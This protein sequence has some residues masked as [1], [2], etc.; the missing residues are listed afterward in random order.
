MWHLWACPANS[1][2]QL[3]LIE[4]PLKETLYIIW[5]PNHNKVKMGLSSYVHQ[6]FFQTCL[7]FWKWNSNL[8]AHRPKKNIQYYPYFYAH[9]VSAKGQCWMKT[10]AFPAYRCRTREEAGSSS[11]RNFWK[12]KGNISKRFAWHTHIFSSRSS[13]VGE[14]GGR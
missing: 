1:A 3:N 14:E 10:F 8:E 7:S 13:G 4:K 2:L 5:S 6:N 9:Q 11:N 12:V